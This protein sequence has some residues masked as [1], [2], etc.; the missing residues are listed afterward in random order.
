MAATS[1]FAQSSVTAYG[2]VD[3][4]WQTN[5]QT[6]RDGAKT[7]NAK[8][9]GAGAIGGSRIGFRGTE[10]LGGGTQAQFLLEQ[11]IEPSVGDGF[12]TRTSGNGIAF[13]SSA[14]TTNDQIRQAYI[15]L[16]DA[17]LG[18]VRLG[19]VYGLTYD[20]FTFNGFIIGENAGNGQAGLGTNSRIRGLQYHAPDMSGLKLSAA[21]GGG[22]SN[23]AS[24][25]GT[26]DTVTGKKQ[27]KDEY[28]AYRAMYAT[29]ALSAGYSYETLKQSCTANGAV[30]AATGGGTYVSKVQNVYGGEVVPADCTNTG[31]AKT[32]TSTLVGSYDF[33][34]AKLM[35]I[36]SNRDVGLLTSLTESRKQKTNQVTVKVPVGKAEFAY[37]S[38]TTTL[39]N[40]VAGTR[41]SNI[42][43]SYALATY[44]MSKRTKVY[45]FTGEDD[46]TATV[47]TAAAT[48]KVKRSGVGI[49]HSF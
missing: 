31:E 22:D 9:L 47:A 46:N 23:M 4:A 3:Q 12:N 44:D 43:G 20:M 48:D 27:S 6:S 33:G 17:K 28:M 5:A 11:G 15:G 41:Q 49:W 21:Y 40:N 8:Y 29:G 10:D 30:A 32:K 37:N 25:T 35:A 14:T 38:Y 18:T 36:S 16:S 45:A 26:E 34:V 2:I 7:Q 42:K 39:D 24:L 13:K 1:A 19:R